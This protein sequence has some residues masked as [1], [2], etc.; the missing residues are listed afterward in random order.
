AVRNLQVRGLDPFHWVTHVLRKLHL[1]SVVIRPPDGLKTEEGRLVR[2]LS[3]ERAGMTK[4]TIGGRLVATYAANVAR[5]PQTIIHVV[6]YGCA[7][8][9]RARDGCAA[10]KG[11]IS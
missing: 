9:D 11:G 5:A 10:G 6:V 3:T 2:I 4:S 1:Q 8:R 7:M